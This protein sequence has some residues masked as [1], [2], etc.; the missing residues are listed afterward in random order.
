MAGHRTPHCQSEQHSMSRLLKLLLAT[1]QDMTYGDNHLDRAREMLD[2]MA[3]H[4]TPSYLSRQPSASRLFDSFLMSRLMSQHRLA[5]RLIQSQWS[6]A[7]FITHHLR[8]TT[9]L[10]AFF[11]LLHSRIPFMFSTFNSCTLGSSLLTIF[12]VDKG[13]TSIQ[14]A[15]VKCT[16]FSRLI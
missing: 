3:D 1:P 7:N 12:H 11:N 2:R 15:C 6:Y 13:W 10:F 14:F 16:L 5:C 4:E 9:L 8:C